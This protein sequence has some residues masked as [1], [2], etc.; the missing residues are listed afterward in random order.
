MN[1]VVK[2]AK[3]TGAEIAKFATKVYQ[4]ATAVGGEVIGQ[5]PGLKAV[6]KAMEG[7]SKAVGAI[8]DHIHAPLSRKLQHGVKIM[9]NVLKVT[10]KA[11]PF[12]R[13]FSEEEAF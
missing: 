7:V 2:F 4:T 13:D 5:I 1:K 3:T 12:R 6:G 8:S 9:N 11:S 10:N